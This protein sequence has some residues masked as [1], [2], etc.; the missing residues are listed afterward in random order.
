MHL[1]RLIA[2]QPL[3]A[4]LTH[5]QLEGLAQAIVDRPYEKGEMVFFE[6][7]PAKGFYIVAQ[8]KVKIYRSAPDGREAVLHVFGPGEPFGE[9]AVFQGG[10]FPAHAMTVEKSHLLFVPR[11]ALVSRIA[12]DP[13]LALNMLAALSGRLRQFAS[14]V[15]ALTLRETPQ[16]LAAYLL[17]A[18]ELK[19]GAD[20]FL[21]DL[22]KGLLAGMLGTARETLSRALTRLADE[23]MVA[24]D[25]RQITLRDRAGLE[26]LAAGLETV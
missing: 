1:V 2:A 22:S 15:E 16:R 21:L 20:T 4:G 10:T 17:T 13:T 3:F 23:G 19:E 14:K 11:E 18:S 5:T 12:S 9:V 7:S 26:A 25:G 24:V 6:S 8:G